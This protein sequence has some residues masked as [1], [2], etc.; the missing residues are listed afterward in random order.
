MPEND[1]SLRSFI[2]VAADSDFPIQNLPFGI[3]T[4]TADDTPRVGV[5]IGDYVLDLACLEARGHF[6]TPLLTGKALFQQSSLN[7][8]MAL[9]RNTAR[10][11]RAIVSQL[12]RHDTPTLRDNVQL[13][14]RAF[15]LQS[16]VTLLLPVTIGS[17]TDFYSSK[18]HATN[19]GRMFR[20]D[21][22]ALLPNWTSLPVGYDGRA[23]MVVV[24]NTPFHRPQG[25]LKLNN[26]E[27]AIFA[28]SR[29]LDVEVEVAF[30]VGQGNKMGE[31]IP[32]AEAPEHVFG[33]VLMND[34]SAR[35]IQKWEYVPLGPFLAKSFCTTISPWVVTLDALAPFAKPGPAQQPTPL[36][37]L[38]RQQDYNF[39]IHLELA[40]QAETMEHPQT[41]ATTNYRH[42]YWDYCQQLAHHTSN[43]CAMQTGDLYGSGTISGPTQAEA[44]SLIELTWGGRDPIQLD[45]GEQRV[46]LAD[47]DQAIIRGWCQGD[48]YRVGFGEVRGQVLPAVK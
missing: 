45:N 16:D 10:E 23:N 1:P 24:S 15:F 39:D 32:I 46:F 8:L 20:P 34:W 48:G 40:L 36:N 42:M 13:R 44:G 12:L 43:G 5:A 3:F 28:P 25:Q 14:E 35:D 26:N 2:D 37:H 9:G 31:P 11:V 18:E 41:I 7:P 22:E 38:Q 30:V 17:Y 27:P 47:N 29:A 21:A 6:D 4:P 19:I 33:V